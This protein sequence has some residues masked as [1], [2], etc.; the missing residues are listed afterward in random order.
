MRSWLGRSWRIGS[1]ELSKSPSAGTSASV[2]GLGQESTMNRPGLLWTGRSR[3]NRLRGGRWNSGK[4]RSV[5]SS[6]RPN[7]RTRPIRKRRFARAESVRW[8]SGRRVANHDT[9]AACAPRNE[10]ERSPPDGEPTP[11]PDLSWVE[12]ERERCRR[13]A[14]HDTRV[15]Y[16]PPKRG[17]AMQCHSNAARKRAG[18]VQSVRSYAIEFGLN[19]SGR[20]TIQW[21]VRVKHG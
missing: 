14:D 1:R 15:A 8:V 11:H 13:A 3:R 4:R 5:G 2:D 17:G 18:L 10:K 20:G 16:A 6:E 12:E 9:R 19:K 7:R 21:L